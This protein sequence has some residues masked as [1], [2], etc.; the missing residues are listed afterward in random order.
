MYIWTRE[1]LGRAVPE[2][3][4]SAAGPAIAVRTDVIKPADARLT[5]FDK[6]SA[7][8]KDF[9]LPEIERVTDKVVASWKTG[10]PI[11]TIYV[12][13]H[14]SPEGPAQY[15]IGL[16]NYRALGVRKAL[17]RA[18][19]RKQKNLSYKVLI[20]AQSKGAREPIDSNETETGRSQNRRV[21]IFLS[22]KA[23]LPLPKKPPPVEVIRPESIP[24]VT[25]PDL[26][27]PALPTDGEPL[28]DLPTYKKE[29]ELC[30]RRLGGAAFDC[31]MTY[32]E[33]EATAAAA[34]SGF[35]AGVVGLVLSGAGAPLAL[36]LA[37]L[38]GI[39]LFILGAHAKV[40]VARCVYSEVQRYND[41]VRAAKAKTHCL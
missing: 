22:T 25:T 15:N 23:L 6:N 5:Q 40:Q 9:H 7:K 14:S 28:C 26:P 13:G 24:W 39:P 18:L 3:G 36:I 10:Q 37:L 4:G 12:K 29:I 31:F 35:A 32:A 41:C 8:L 38:G 16:A 34:A 11:F 21:E 20:L 19:E 1:E 27:G 30:K 2:T 17:Q 33:K